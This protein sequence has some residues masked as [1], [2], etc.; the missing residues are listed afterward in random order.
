M[1]ILWLALLGAPLLALASFGQQPPQPAPNPQPAADP[2]EALLNEAL[3]RW[4]KAMDGL[5]SFAAQCE[6]TSVDKTFQTTD[7]FIGTAKYLRNGQMNMASLE[8]VKKT[9][10]DVFE[11]YLINGRFLYQFAPQQKTIYQHELPKPAQV[12]QNNFLSFIFGMRAAAAKQRYVLTWVPPAANDKWYYYIDI[13]P[14]DAADKADFSRAR[15]YLTA[16]TFLPRR[17]WFEQPNGN[18]IM[19]DFPQVTPNAQINPQ[20][21]ADP[22]PPPGWRIVQAPRQVIRQQQ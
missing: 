9:R 14:R 21:F 12:G 3:A 8:L 20:E 7:V 15:L 5:Q 18:E 17:L 22:T 13:R 19:W 10:K 1:R 16:S 6:R 4:E 11:K 2:N